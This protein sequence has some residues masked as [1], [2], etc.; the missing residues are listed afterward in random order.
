MPNVDENGQ[1]R[2]TF[3]N[4]SGWGSS[5]TEKAP[6]EGA[7]AA[8]PPADAEAAP[9]ADV[10]P[11][12]EQ[13][14]EQATPPTSQPEQQKFNMPPQQRWN[15]V[16]K[17]R[18]E[19][20]ARA[21]QAEQLA[22]LA[23]QKLQTPQAPAVPQADP[24]AGL[25][26]HPDPATARFY[27]QQRSLFQ[28][29]ANR[30]A[31]EKLQGLVQ[32]VE[33]GRSELAQI[34]VERFREK[35]PEITEGSPEEQIVASYLRRGLDLNESKKLAL[36]DKLEAENRALKGKQAAIPRK[37]AASNTESS[38]G[39]P[40]GS[41]LPPKRGDWRDTASE[42]LDKGGSPRDVMNTIFGGRR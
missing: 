27:Q 20:E 11:S 1:E 35:T 25:V 16:I 40:A 12:D 2:Q 26:D 5:I 10:T 42:I 30:A 36:Y 21:R 15:E 6:D 8:S 19:A 34:K 13:V 17:Q 32:A 3:G 31:E 41:G 37:V 29:E 4:P 33:A 18:E 22:Q 7:P 28:A 24:W 9:S 14:S 23:L 39:I 38:A